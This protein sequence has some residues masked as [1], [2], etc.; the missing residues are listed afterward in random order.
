MSSTAIVLKAR[1][2]HTLAASSL[3]LVSLL[4]GW[5]LFSALATEELAD[6]PPSLPVDI[7]EEIAADAVNLFFV[8]DR[9]FTQPPRAR[10]A[11]YL[12]RTSAPSS[13]SYSDYLEYRRGKISRAELVSRLPHVAMIGDS[14]TQNFHTSNPLSM[15][16]RART[17]RRKN[18]FLD[19]DPAPQSIHSVYERLDEVTP[20]VAIQYSGA[21]ALVAPSR[22][23]EGLRRRMIRT[24][25]L[26][27]QTRQ[28]LRK[29]RFPDLIMIWIGHNNTDWVEGLSALEREHPQKHMRD[30][31]ARFGENYTESLRDLLDRAK[32]EKHNVAIVVFGLVN[33]DAFFKGR[34]KAEALH[35]RNPAA[36]PY[37][38]TAYKSFESLKPP[39]QKNMALL[40][41]MLNAEIQTMVARLQWELKNYPNVRLQYSDA[42]RK[43]DFSRLELIN[44]ADA[45]HLSIDG[46]KALAEAAFRAI[47]PSLEFVGAARASP[48][49]AAQADGV[50]QT[51]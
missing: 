29:K 16:W 40:G 35:A 48:A 38:E 31:A 37:L 9:V 22:A 5:V 21:G 3:W 42:L 26:S 43:V 36:Y 7:G 10:S 13:A 30:M 46:H 6:R 34:R 20:L 28:V 49:T 45:W 18:W 1:T 12:A 8:F 17:E 24:R 11:N 47:A 27:G 44:P 25:N 4:L 2:N 32:A 19:T 41:S 15:F 23:R 50:R 14:L 51:R 33:F 39:Y